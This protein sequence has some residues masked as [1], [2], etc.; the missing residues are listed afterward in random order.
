MPTV[1]RLLRTPDGQAE[2]ERAR[3]NTV[4]FA[5]HVRKEA[6]E[7]S[8]TLCTAVGRLC[9]ESDSAPNDRSDSALDA[10]TSS[11]ARPV[12]MFERSHTANTVDARRFSVG[13]GE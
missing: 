5:Q 7:P 3:A 12:P 9:G 10:R 4:T 11:A 13:D 8:G 6:M 1:L 2:L